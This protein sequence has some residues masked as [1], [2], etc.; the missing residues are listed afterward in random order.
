MANTSILAFN[1]KRGVVSFGRE[2]VQT[3]EDYAA[4]LNERATELRQNWEARAGRAMLMRYEDLVRS[5]EREL[6][7]LL[8]Y[9]GLD[10]SRASVRAL[11]ENAGPLPETQ[12]HRTTSDALRSIGRWQHDLSPSLQAVVND[13]FRDNLEA[14]GYTT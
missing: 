4:W 3:D 1:R 8:K 6:E 13:V 5:P 9:L 12:Q 2:T 7:R 11:I 10:H 14:F